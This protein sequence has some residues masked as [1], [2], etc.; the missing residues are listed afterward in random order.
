MLM[1]SIV[2]EK[3]G[4]QM[5]AGYLMRWVLAVFISTLLAYTLFLMDTP[6]IWGIEVTHKEII[7]FAAALAVLSIGLLCV[8]FK[9]YKANSGLETVFVS[10]T[11]STATVLVFKIIFQDI[12]Q[13]WLS[14]GLSIAASIIT[15]CLCA[16]IAIEANYKTLGLCAVVMLEYYIFFTIHG[17]TGERQIDYFLLTVPS[18][19]VAIWAYSS[20]YYSLAGDTFKTWNGIA[21]LA[22]ATLAAGLLTCGLIAGWSVGI[23]IAC[24]C[25]TLI[26]LVLG[27]IAEYMGIYE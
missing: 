10:Y 2:Q 16:F 9:D 12:N 19:I 21:I 1:K 14:W 4:E 11:A 17:T 23:I 3:Q 26:T 18:V 25:V 22:L 6:V 20:L 5:F 15:V 8:F 27:M 13:E 7:L 24:V